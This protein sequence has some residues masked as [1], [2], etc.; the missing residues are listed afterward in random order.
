[1]EV[2]GNKLDYR[3]LVN[4]VPVV[5]I[6]EKIAIVGGFYSGIVQIIFIRESK[7]NNT[8]RFPLLTITAIGYYDDYRYLYLG[9]CEGRLIVYEVNHDA[10]CI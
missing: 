5:V 3:N 7:Y 4:F 1:M 10:K 8:F 2:G 6:H 9:D